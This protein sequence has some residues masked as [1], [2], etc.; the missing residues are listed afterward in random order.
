MTS[1]KQEVAYI[2]LQSTLRNKMLSRPQFAADNL[3]SDDSIE[4]FVSDLATIEDEFGA[5]VS[6]YCGKFMA[7]KL[8]TRKRMP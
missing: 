8:P 3:T 5:E 7:K 1:K 4:N 6:A 2:Q